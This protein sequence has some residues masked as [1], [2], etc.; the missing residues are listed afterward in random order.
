[1][2]ALDG[3]RL[4]AFGRKMAALGNEPRL[5]AML[6]AAQTDDE[7]ATAAKLAAILEEPRGGLVDLGAVFS[8]QQANWQQRAQQLMKRPPAAAASPMPG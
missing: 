4:S 6:A 2:S 7:A 8:R 5:A 1:M 3:E